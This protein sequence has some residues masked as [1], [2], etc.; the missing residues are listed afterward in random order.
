[1]CCQTHIE[2]RM[3][4]TDFKQ[5]LSNLHLIFYLKKCKFDL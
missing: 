4:N 5:I 1:M 3:E 2:R